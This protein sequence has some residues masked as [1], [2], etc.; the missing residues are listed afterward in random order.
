[1]G[2]MLP[3][4]VKWAC[5][6]V[7]LGVLAGAIFPRRPGAEGADEQAQHD[8]VT[9]LAIKGMTCS[10]CAGSVRRAVLACPGV[11]AA[12]VDLATGR[13][14]VSGGEAEALGKAVEALGFSVTGARAPD[15]TEQA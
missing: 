7:L 2:W 8:D 12:D 14:T 3:E 11:T 6:V 13:A 4:P 5:A 9:T 1:M 10:H 15:R